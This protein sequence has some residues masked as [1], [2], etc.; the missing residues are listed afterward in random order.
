MKTVLQTSLAKIFR[1]SQPDGI[2]PGGF[3]MLLNER[4]CFQLAVLPEA[5][6]ELKVTVDGPLSGCIEMSCVMQIPSGLPAYENHD[7]DVIRS[8]PG[9]YPDCLRPAKHG[10]PCEKGVWQSVWFE[11]DPDGRYPAGTYTLSVTAAD[12]DGSDTKQLFIKIINAS[13]PEQELICTHWFHSDCI[14]THY[15][16]P[17]FSEEYWLLVERFMRAANRHGINFILTPLF[18]PPLDTAVGGERPTVQLT[19]V[20]VTGE[21]KYSFGFDNLNRFVDLALKCGMKYFEMS[22]LF[23]QWGAKHAP[24]IVD[25]RG[26]QLF[27]WDTRAR[28][29]KYKAFLTQFAAALTEFIDK[30]GIRDKCFFHVSDEPGILQLS[31]Y[32][33]AAKLVEKLFPGFRVIDALSDYEFYLTGLVKNPI[34]A[35]NHI[36]PFLGNVPKL[37]T[38]YCCGQYVD[39][40]NRFFSMPSYRNRVLG[41]QLY[42]NDCEGFLQWGYNFWYTRHSVRSVDPFTESDAGGAFPSGDAYQVY[43]GTDGEPWISLRF[44]VFFDGLQDM[45]ALRLLESLIGRE[46]ALAL[47]DDGLEQ[48]L[49]FDRYPKSEKILLDKREK[50]NDAIEKCS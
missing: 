27:G 15:G 49:A 1:D 11:I 7:D 18:T 23:T 33:Y 38:Y 10:F 47:L 9:L 29:R 8:S 40:S 14:A 24:K 35:T 45:R 22:H 26:E 5:D 34:P 13:L 2:V 46:K 32:G 50:I 16:V 3:S 31:S 30:K 12:P 37:W 39:V 36:K 6:G 21:D 20:T 42:K 48:P 19:E 44:K 43:P 28:S 41:M 25:C 4:L 17:V